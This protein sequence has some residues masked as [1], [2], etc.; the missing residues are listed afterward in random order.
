[1]ENEEIMKKRL[2]TVLI[3]STG[4]FFLYIS[5]VCACPGGHVKGVPD[6]ITDLDTWTMKIQILGNTESSMNIGLIDYAKIKNDPE[7]NPKGIRQIFYMSMKAGETRT[8]VT[9]YNDESKAPD[10][11]TWWSE[12]RRIRRHSK[13]DFENKEYEDTTLTLKQIMDAAVKLTDRDQVTIKDAVIFVKE[14]CINLEKIM[15]P[16]PL[17]APS[18]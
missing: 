12:W 3:V 9:L 4:I 18:Y 2:L 6:D 1:L 7:R 8:Q 14:R 11:Y 5:I 10:S 13:I 17:I 16:V 15:I